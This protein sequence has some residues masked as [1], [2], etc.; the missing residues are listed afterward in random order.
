MTFTLVFQSKFAQYTSSLIEQNKIIIQQ[1]K[2]ILSI[3]KTKTVQGGTQVLLSNPELPVK[4]PV[5]TF[6]STRR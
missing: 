6:G 5:E 1:N 2:E 4:F 3:L